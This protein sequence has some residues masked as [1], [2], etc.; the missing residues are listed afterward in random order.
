[1]RRPL[2]AFCRSFPE[3]AELDQAYLRVLGTGRFRR[4]KQLQS[5]FGDLHYFPRSPPPAAK[6]FDGSGVIG[7]VP[8][9]ILFVLGR[10]AED[11]GSPASVTGKT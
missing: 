6:I 10:R 3:A 1:V 4:K 11:P 2:I 9:K 5:F 8:S 7:P